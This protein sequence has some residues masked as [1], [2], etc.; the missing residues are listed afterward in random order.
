MISPGQQRRRRPLFPTCHPKKRIW[1]WYISSEAACFVGG[2]GNEEGKEKKGKERK[3]KEKKEKKDLAHI[4][5]YAV[6]SI[7]FP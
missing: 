6:I 7:L 4:S 3:E 5:W 1:H 2:L